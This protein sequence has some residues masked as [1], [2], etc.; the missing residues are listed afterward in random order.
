MRQTLIAG[1]WKMQGT[2]SQAENYLDILLPKLPS[3]LK[4]RV[5]LAVP[6]TLLVTMAKR[7]KD[8]LLEIGAQDMSDQDAGAF[9][10]EISCSMLQ[11]SGS[12]FV[13]LGHSE[14]RQLFHESDE[15]IHKKIIKAVS[16]NMQPILC[17]GETLE[18]KEAGLAEKTLRK[19]ILEALK[20]LSK[21][22]A[23]NVI[24]AY[25]PIWAIGT[26]INATPDLANDMHQFC[27]NWLGELFSKEIAD[28]LPIIYGGSVK[29]DN[30]AS[31]LEKE[32]I[33]GVL[34][35]GASLDPISFLHIIQSS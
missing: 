6:F 35:G 15:L 27:R 31:F 22:E 4:K 3:S 26:G 8:S 23:S 30:V 13:I 2:L 12:K 33:D 17:V 24:I 28:N 25:E 21:E 34:V 9:T 32:H 18:E 10:G 29:P 20:G 1:N 5:L 19:Q 16:L 7:A 14:R 11:D